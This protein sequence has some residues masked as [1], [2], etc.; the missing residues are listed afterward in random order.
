MRRETIHCGYLPGLAFRNRLLHG[1]LS[2]VVLGR[3]RQPCCVIDKWARERGTLWGRRREVWVCVGCG[4]VCACV[5]MGVCVGMSQHGE[6]RAS[7]RERLPTP[8]QRALLPPGSTW[9]WTLEEP[10]QGTMS[11]CSQTLATAASSAFCFLAPTLQLL[12]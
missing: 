3:G 6:S 9:F 4:C 7:L 12:I 2:G 10:M 5:C 11:R 1:L 8:T